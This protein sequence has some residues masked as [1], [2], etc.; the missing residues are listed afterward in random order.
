MHNGW[1]DTVCLYTKE[2]MLIA[3]PTAHGKKTKVTNINRMVVREF[4]AN[5]HS[6]S[7]TVSV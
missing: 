1:T 6:I 5:Y 3:H 2:Y 7:F 4:I